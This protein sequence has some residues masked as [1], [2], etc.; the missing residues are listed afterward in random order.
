MPASAPSAHAKPAPIN[1]RTGLP[2]ERR[3]NFWD[4]SERRR[5][6]SALLATAIPKVL[7]GKLYD[8][9]G[10]WFDFTQGAFLFPDR[11]TSAA[12]RSLCEQ[13]LPDREV[14][15][16][17]RPVLMRE[18]GV[19]CKELSGWWFGDLKDLEAARV[20]CAAQMKL[21]L[22]E[23]QEPAKPPTAA[24]SASA[25]TTPLPVPHTPTVDIRTEC[26]RRRREGFFLLL[27]AV[28]IPA[29]ELRTLDAIP[30]CLEGQLVGY[31]LPSQVA[32]ER[33]QGLFPSTPAPPSSAADPESAASLIN[34]LTG[35]LAGPIG[36]ALGRILRA[37]G[38]LPSEQSQ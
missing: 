16:S 23:D 13:V 31:L 17:L 24:A 7:N 4:Y 10:A 6:G 18:G 37:E 36:N 28:Q 12:A 26:E 32:L 11:A 25:R 8:D 21:N 20:L 14:P 38:V 5:Q 9:F 30:E 34:N 1:R 29:E 27:A 2:Y 15:H 33:A 22:P 35:A 3:L 19:W